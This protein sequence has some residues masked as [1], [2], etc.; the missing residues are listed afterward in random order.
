MLEKNQKRCLRSRLQ[1][2]HGDDPPRRCCNALSLLVSE[3]ARVL[4]VRPRDVSDLYY[5]R[6]LSDE[7]CPVVGG[8]RLIP[9]DYVGQVEKTL[10]ERGTI[11]A[12][13]REPL[14]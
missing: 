6:V 1:I 10:R 12:G 14:A 3:V 13:S 9:D 8:R 5:Q 7:M 11:S 2:A 4:V